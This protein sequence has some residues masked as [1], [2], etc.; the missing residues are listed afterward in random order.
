MRLRLFSLACLLLGLSLLAAGCGASS[1]E[2]AAADDG[3]PRT[4]LV[5]AAEKAPGVPLPKGDPPKKLVIDDLREGY[6]QGAR[7]GDLIVT[8]FVAEFV[9]G[10]R[11][12]PVLETVTRRNSFSPANSA[13][14]PNR[15]DTA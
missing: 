9:T 5:A 7:R 15:Y 12:E 4:T 8:K 11:G 3:G 1:D 13:T 14:T 6:G 2:E 10:M